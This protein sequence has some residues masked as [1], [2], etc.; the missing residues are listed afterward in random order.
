MKLT[1]NRR[2]ALFVLRYIR[3]HHVSGKNMRRIDLI[4]PNPTPRKRWSKT[5]IDLSRFGVPDSFSDDIPLDVAVSNRGDYLR[6]K[7]ASNTL[8]GAEGNLPPNSFIEVAPGLAISC[9]ELMF[10]E[11]ATVMDAPTH[12]MLGHELCGG[13]ARDSIDPLNGPV[14]LDCPPVTSCT[15]LKAYLEKTKWLSGA[16]QAW[17]TLELLSDNAWSP[18]ESIIAAMASL[19]LAEFGYGLSVSMN[20]RIYTPEALSGVTDASSR[21]PD[22]LFNDTHVGIN[23]DGAVH[24]DLNSIVHVAMDAGRNPG[25]AKIGYALDQVIRE[26]R[27]KAVDDIR[28]NRELAA[29][30]FIVFPVTKEDL[31]EEGGLD[32]VMM[33]VIE[34]LEKFGQ[35]DVG[36]HRRMM[37]SKFVRA[38]RQELVWSLLPGR[39]REYVS[40]RAEALP[41]LYASAHVAEYEIERDGDQLTLRS[42]GDREA[43]EIALGF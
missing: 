39:H 28:R 30:G 35:Q 40:N 17:C 2:T 27:A 37:K 33:Q 34:A 4:A 10:I 25:D 6:M 11:M 42:H 7:F 41:Y 8:Y 1:I 5:A 31:Y 18:T 24:L 16:K 19:P 12:L 9:P 36:K 15:K 38:K 23:Y 20:E 21:V 32:R 3:T 43:S 26:V 14:K 29:S 22:I 13:F